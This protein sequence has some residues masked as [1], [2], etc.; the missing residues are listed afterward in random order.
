MTAL[1]EPPRRR[2]TAR[3]PCHNRGMGTTVPGPDADANPPGAE[4]FAA[5]ERELHGIAARLL[6]AERTG[7]TLQPTA[8]LHEAW[9]RLAGARLPWR[10]RAHFVQAAASSM[11]R[12]LV[13]HARARAA[14][15]RGGG[16]QR[17]TLAPE[18]LECAAGPG[19]VVAVDEIL[20]RLAALDPE[21]G[22]IV[23]LRVF[24][25]LAH[26]EIAEVLHTSLRTVE[27]GWRLARAFLQRELG[28]GDGH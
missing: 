20:R 1:R 14:E 26:P 15:K 22:R 2:R 19:D 18:L 9:L 16:A 12:I 25:G 7:H 27:R 13:E 28:G 6:Q 8:L 4:H 24:G 3:R 17:V 10:D 21:L 11:R 23:E 5:V